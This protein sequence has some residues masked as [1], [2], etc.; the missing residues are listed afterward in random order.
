MSDT[1][2]API[3]ALSQRTFVLASAGA[4]LVPVV[5]AAVLADPVWLAMTAVPAAIAV[6]LGMVRARAAALP[7]EIAPQVLVGRVDGVKVFRFRARL[8]HGRAASRAVATATWVGEDGVEVPLSVEPAGYARVIGAWTVC[9]RDRG[10]RTGAGGELRVVVTA[11]ERSRAWRAEARWPATEIRRG[12][13]DGAEVRGGRLVDVDW[14]RVL[15]E[16]EL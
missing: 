12:R 6:G 3:E 11:E 5:L 7:L 14:D 15:P 2:L 1:W 4:V 10:G 13:F 16:E 8:G 9:A